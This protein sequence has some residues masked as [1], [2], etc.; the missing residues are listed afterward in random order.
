MILLLLSYIFVKFIKLMVH[1]AH[2]ISGGP[3][4][5]PGWLP[6]ESEPVVLIFWQTKQPIK[7]Y[8]F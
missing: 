4:E 1:G 2:A 6:N 7:S 5:N 3:L 8:V